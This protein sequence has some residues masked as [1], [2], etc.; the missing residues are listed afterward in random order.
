MSPSLVSL[1]IYQCPYHRLP[2]P[3]PRTSLCA[4]VPATDQHSRSSVQFAERINE[5][6]ENCSTH[7]PLKLLPLLTE[8]KELLLSDK[9]G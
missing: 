2:S 9:I 6:Q 5:C 4:P 8:A 7:V 3:A 1:P